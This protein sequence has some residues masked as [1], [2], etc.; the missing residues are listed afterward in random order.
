MIRDEIKE[1]KDKVKQMS[2]L[3]RFQYFWYYNWIKVVLICTVLLFAAYFALVI[4]H[5]RGEE[6][7]Y[8]AMVNCVMTGEDQQALMT[9]FTESRGIDT[10]DAPARINANMQLAKDHYN[11]VSLANSQ[12]LQA[13]ME[14]GDYDVLIAD[15]WIIRDFASQA[16]LC[17]LSDTLPEDIYE[18]IKDNL[19][20]Y[21]YNDGTH[22]PVGFYADRLEK[23]SGY[24]QDGIRPIVSLSRISETQEI[25]VQ[26]VEYLL[27]Q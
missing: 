22:I 1:Q 3:K 17:D 10:S 4:Y 18:Q 12:S 27:E 8:V 2:G 16:L 5:N 25:G 9:G 13:Y 24:Y 11:N 6:S 20:Y 26:F 23:I 14:T 21:D 15:E 7:I 19:Y